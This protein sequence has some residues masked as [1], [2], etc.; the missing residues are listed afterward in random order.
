MSGREL[1]RFVRGCL[2]LTLPHD[3][4]S[5]ILR[6]L[7]EAWNR[8][9]A[10][11]GAFSARLWLWAQAV[12]F[13]TRFAPARMGEVLGRPRPTSTDLKLALRSAARAPLVTGLSVASLGI[14]I[15]A[16]LGGFAI[17]QGV[18]RDLPYPGGERIMLVADYNL[19]D[20]FAFDMGYDEYARRRDALTTFEY[21][22]AYVQRTLVVGEGEL[23]AVF[24]AIFATPG[25]LRLTGV[26]PMLGRLADEGD[27]VPGAEPVVV[28]PHSAW[29]RLTGSDPEVI[30]TVVELGGVDRTVIGVMPEG[31][32]FPWSEVPWIPFDAR[33][34]DSPLRVVGK[35]RAEVDL[36]VARAELAAIARPDPTQ[37]E[38]GTAV[39]HLVTPITRPTTNDAQVYVVLVP[40]AILVLLLLVMATNVANL[41]LAR[42]ASRGTELAIRGA[43][44]ASRGRIVGQLAAEVV[45]M[46]VPA[47]V[48][49]VWVARQ[50]VLRVEANLDL[51]PWMDLSLQPTSLL[52]AVALAALVTFVA[53]VT[54]ALKATG[55]A[56]GEAL[57][58]A[59]RRRL[60]HPFRPSHGGAHRDT[61]R[62]LRGPSVLGYPAR[63]VAHDVRV[64]AVRPP[65]RRGP[66]RP[67]LLRLARRAERPG[68]AL[69]SRGAG[70]DP[71]SVPA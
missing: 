68:S 17:V 16:A 52:F 46:V 23:A 71:G 6:D 55:R 13:A 31:F 1:P 4:R 20:R 50:A 56:P 58:R 53:G 15:G 11:R 22:E 67:D 21:F 2:R 48:L 59:G 38:P 30:G 40:V 45:A 28:L 63:P 37:V 3:W 47:A 60:R 10:D 9:R 66:G 5:D 27:V 24:P 14:G 42:N 18:M 29:V 35:L 32:G 70:R 57:R 61:D 7:E 36:A 19:Q 64:R 49:G 26:S 62:H 69:R 25:F 54:P 44:G 34:S 41:V 51:P 12:A 8:R 43:L 65:G 33:E 39:R